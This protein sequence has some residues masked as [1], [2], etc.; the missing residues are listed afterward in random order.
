MILIITI[1]GPSGCGKTTLVRGILKRLGSRGTELISCTTRKPRPMEKDGVDYYFVSRDDFKDRSSFL[2]VV[3]FDGNFYGLKL[4]ELVSKYSEKDWCFIVVNPDGAKSISEYIKDRFGKFGARTVYISIN[5][6]LAFK[7]LKRRDG[8]NKAKSR[9]AY[10][11]N[12]N[13]YNFNGYD[14][15]ISNCS[16]KE[17]LINNLHNYLVAMK[18]EKELSEREQ[19]EEL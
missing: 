5:P 10:D 16:S 4:D 13:M 15:V 19:G 14:C 2:E 18:L 1:T 12:N 17:E 8:V 11:M 3:E 6:E 9:Q 7:N